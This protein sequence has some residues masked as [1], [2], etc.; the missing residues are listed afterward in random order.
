MKHHHAFVLSSWILVVL[1]ACSSSKGANATDGSTSS[2]ADATCGTHSAPGIMTLSNLSPAL[3]STVVNQNI[4]HGFTVVHAVAN[5]T[6]FTLAY[7]S[8]HTAG[9][10][11]PNAPQVHTTVS[12]SD[13]IYQFTINAWSRAPAHVEILANGGFDTSAGCTWEFPSPLFSYDITAAP[14][15]GGDAAS[16]AGA[17]ADLSPFGLDGPSPLGVDSS[18]GE[19]GLVVDGAGGLDVP[20]GAGLDGAIDT[21][22]PA[23]D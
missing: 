10:S 15:Q 13:V 20:L 11:T 5:F 17:G 14:G 16:E 21:T 22:T 18:T 2:Q 6:N 7:G 3:G 19:T 4:A 9:L 1:S 8:G 23:L 12:G